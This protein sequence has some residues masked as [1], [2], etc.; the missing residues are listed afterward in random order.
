MYSI[1]DYVMNEEHFERFETER[2]ALPKIGMPIMNTRFFG[3]ID[4]IIK[5][6]LIPVMLGK[7]QSQMNK[8]VYYDA[9]QITEW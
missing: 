5:D 6:F 1:K 8:S 2:N 4:A 7:Q 3:P 9:N